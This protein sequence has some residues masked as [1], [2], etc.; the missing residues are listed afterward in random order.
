MSSLTE[1]IKL[2]IENICKITEKIENRQDYMEDLKEYIPHMN[3]II[4][5]IINLSTDSRSN[6]DLNNEFVLQ[7]LKDILYGVEN[8]DSVFLQD[9]L[10]NGLLEIYK[11]IITE[12]EGESFYE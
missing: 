5:K 4:P 3:Q 1:Q 7:V 10:Q 12:L 9:V 2:H 6:L 11:Y 8:E